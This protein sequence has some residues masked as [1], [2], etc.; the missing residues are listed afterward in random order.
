MSYI[1]IDSQLF[2]KSSNDNDP[3][4]GQF[5][6]SIGD[7]SPQK[8]LVVVGYGDDEGTRLNGGRLGSKDAPDKIR[9]FFYKTTPYE[10]RKSLMSQKSQVL[11]DAGNL[12]I[13]GSLADRHEAAKKAAVQFFNSKNK[14]LSLG[15]SHDYAYADGAAFLT[16]FGGQKLKPLIINFDAHSDCRP[17]DRGLT[18]GT[19]FYRLLSEFEGK[20]DFMEFGLL[21]LCNSQTY[22]DW[23]RSKKTKLFFSDENTKALAALKKAIAKKR[24]IWVSVD[25]DVFSSNLSSGTSNNWPIGMT[26]EQFLPFYNLLL[27]KNIAGLGLYETIPALDTSDITVKLAASLAHAF[28]ESIYDQLGK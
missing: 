14:I 10:T 13:A 20:F 24:P 25:L 27:S 21:K 1:S 5:F 26:L 28:T 16:V 6:A 9:Q 12:K 2:F 17:T 8:S 19:P 23:A 4:Y 7:K 18:S 22:V 11:F 15:G 3:R